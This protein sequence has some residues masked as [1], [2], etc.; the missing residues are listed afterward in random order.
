MILQAL[1]KCYE[2]LLKIGAI[3][4]PGW[5]LTNISYALCLNSEGKLLQ[6]VSTMEETTNVSSIVDTI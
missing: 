2:D 3:A 4:S 5:S 1:T 6:I